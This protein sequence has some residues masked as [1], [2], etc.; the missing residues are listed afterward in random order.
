MKQGIID[1]CFIIDWSKYSKKELLKSLFKRVFIHEEILAQLKSERPIFLASKWLSEKF[2][3]LYPQTSL[4]E[5][6]FEKLAEEVRKYPE[7]PIHQIDER[8]TSKIAKQS[9]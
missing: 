8:F 6:L 1:A 4:S 3:A 7:I 5:E 9:I 2:M